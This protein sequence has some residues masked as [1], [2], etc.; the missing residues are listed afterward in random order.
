MG[1]LVSDASLPRRTQSQLI[2]EIDKLRRELSTLKSENS[3]LQKLVKGS[4]QGIIVVGLPG[5]RPLFA[6]EAVARMYGYESAEEMMGLETLEVI[7]HPEDRPGMKRQDEKFKTDK[8]HFFNEFRG[9]RKDG[10]IIDIYDMVTPIDWNGEMALLATSI[11]ITERKRAEAEL[12]DS[13]IRYR[14]IYQS[15]SVGI[16]ITDA[17]GNIIHSNLAYQNMLG[18]SADELLNL[19][20]S[21]ITPAEDL[22]E[23]LAMF[24]ELISGLRERVD[25]EKRYIRK[26]GSI[27]WVEISTSLLRNLDSESQAALS[28]VHDVT[29]R[30]QTEDALQFAQFSLDQAG[31]AVSWIGESGKLEYVNQSY[32]KLF[33]Y[34]QAKL[35]SMYVWDLDPNV[36]QAEWPRIWARLIKRDSHTFESVFLIKD[37]EQ[38]PVEVTTTHVSLGDRR[39]ICSVARDITERKR[40]QLALKESEERLRLITDNLP[41]FICYVDKDGIYRFANKFY[42]KAFHRPLDQIIGHHIKDIIG[43]ES[44]DANSES[45]RRVLSGETFTSL[46]EIEQSGGQLRSILANYMPDM[47]AENTVL[48]FYVLAQDVTDLKRGEAALRESEARYREIFDDAPAALWVEDWSPVK[49]MIDRLSEEGVTNW[50]AYFAENRDRAIEAYDLAKILQISKASLDLFDATNDQEYITG[51]RGAL[52]LPEELDAFVEI[53]LDFIEGKWKF[54]MESLDAKT[55]G[56]KIMLRTR[57]IVPLAH[58][59][60]WSRLVYSLEDVTERK[61]TE[62]ALM[63]AMEQTA[64]ANRTM[65]EFLAH[66]SHEL[67]TP[68]NAIIGFSHI[69]KSEMFGAVGNPKYLEYANDINGSSVHLLGIISDILDLSKV[70][71]GKTELQEENV[72]VVKTLESCLKLVKERA[73]EAGITF[74]RHPAQNGLVLYADELKLKQVLINLLSNAIDFTPTGG[75]IATKIDRSLDGG[76]AIQI[77]DTGIGMAPEDIPKALAPFQQI[78]NDLNRGNRGTGLGLSLTKSLT[79]LHGGSLDIQSEI[80]V[81]TTVTVQFPAERVVSGKTRQWTVESNQSAT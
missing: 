9:I 25:F 10:S 41:A 16:C 45:Y 77:A 39:F 67:R 69:M 40:S 27:C 55:D 23:N 72:D 53:L 44:Y 18:F 7:V 76:L 12:R 81:G 56:T 43:Q 62:E 11:D 60:D 20:F 26:D 64:L 14:S 42:E 29:E 15:A 57:G 50:R 1:T 17:N 34:S 46:V 66:M 80:G 49:K 33:G 28:V 75:T 8:T 2:D 48:G 71:S 47:D 35:L 3:K 58:R 24:E 6:N 36:A 63:S 59:H 19:N 54:D 21:D 70:Q 73:E 61:R 5:W 13:E 68:L 52:V 4:I 51:F 78:K 74:N 32:Q 22:G 65:S 31:D 38:V 30:K 37:G 79:E